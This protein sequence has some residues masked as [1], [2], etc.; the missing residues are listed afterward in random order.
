MTGT[1]NSSQLAPGAS[2][3]EVVRPCAE[4]TGF[5]FASPHSGDHYPRDFL[6]RSVLP[7]RLLR[8]SEDAFVDALY[9]DAPMFGAPLVRA[10]FPRA[11]VDPNRAATELD[12]AM[13]T[14]GPPAGAWAPSSR[15]AAGLG[16][17]PRLAA[18]GRAIYAGRLDY[19]E[20]RARL[21]AC[22]VPYHAA[23]AQEIERARAAFGSAIVI[24]CHSMPS[25]SAR[26]ADVVLGD[27]FGA[28]CARGLVAAAEAEFREAGFAVARN[29][30]YAGG[31]TTEHYGR[32]E[33][34]VH[35]L[36]VEINRGLY[37]NEG[38]VEPH[39]GFDRLRAAL[40]AWMGAMTAGRGE[41]D[42]Q[43]AE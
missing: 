26:G 30:P 17:I 36:Q 28:S 14:G 37:M 42:L 32:P 6:A 21:K 10:R 9:A 11:F 4:P 29:R 38:R 13:F 39:G 25:A 27:R 24:D 23:L 8:R 12:P 5:V 35:V 41:A 15:A 40:S 33:A 7:L 16:V 31:Y 3:V 1:Q 43:A 18:D 2:P 19:A 20:A 22:Y 34:G